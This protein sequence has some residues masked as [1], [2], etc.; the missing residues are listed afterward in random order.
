[1]EQAP[2]H[3]PGKRFPVTGNSLGV[4]VVFAVIGYQGAYI[5]PFE[6]ASRLAAYFGLQLTLG[7]MPWFIAAVGAAAGLVLGAISNNN[8]EQERS[9]TVQQKTEVAARLG[10]HFVPGD[11]PALAGKIR[12]HFRGDHSLRARDVMDMKLNG[13]RLEVVTISYATGV[14]DRRT[15][16]DIAALYECP[17]L[18]LPGFLLQPEQSLSDFFLGAS[19]YADIDFPE[20]PEFSKAYHLCGERPDLIRMLFDDEVLELLGRRR[21]LQIR[22]SAGALLVLDPAVEAHGIEAFA[23]NAAEIF[24]QFDL[25][26]GRANLIPGA[27]TVPPP[28]PAITA[29]RRGV[30]GLLNPTEEP[31]ARNAVVEFIRTLPPRPITKLFAAY[32]DRSAPRAAAG[33]GIMF[34]AAGGLFGFGAPQA[35]SGLETMILAA[36]SG[37]LLLVGAPTAFFG[38]RARWR[39]TRLLR[40]GRLVEAFVTGLEETGLKINGQAIYRMTVKYSGQDG[41][42]EASCRIRGDAVL[43]AQRLIGKRMAAQVLVDPADPRRVLFADDLLTVSPEVEP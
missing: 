17:H 43:R 7:T 16:T 30:A 38:L 14:S 1:M 9:E 18:R 23:R 13:L 24:A 32:R 37:V 29:P 21:G 41:T 34:L 3:R 31:V 33:F 5:V 39:L 8:E 4:A 11:S 15:V 2:Q 27:P 20:Q 6:T 22:S 42:A 12:E 19:G 28:A 10:A 40:H 26:A 25:S 36:F 35:S